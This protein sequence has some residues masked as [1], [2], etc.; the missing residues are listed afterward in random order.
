MWG[1]CGVLGLQETRPKRASGAQLQLWERSL[2]TRSSVRGQSTSS[3]T[4]AKAG[5]LSNPGHLKPPALGLE[6]AKK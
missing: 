4:T 2:F 1:V 6:K 5:C 3:F